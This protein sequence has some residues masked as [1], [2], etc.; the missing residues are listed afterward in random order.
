GP[1]PVVAPAV[2]PAAPVLAGAVD[3]ALEVVAVGERE[4]PALDR[5][6]R[7]EA[8][9]AGRRL[10]RASDVC[11]G[12]ARLPGLPGVDRDDEVAVP[13]R[14]GRAA[15]HPDARL[16]AAPV[17]ARLDAPAH[18]NRALEPFDPPRHLDP[19][20]ERAVAEGQRV[21]NARRAAARPVGRL[22]D[23]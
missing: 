10:E 3:P 14:H 7:E 1:R 13:L 15:A 4:R 2:E 18:P 5:G 8:T 6:E 11:V 20:P 17:E 19:P 21:R 23:V 12:D 9:R 16:A 22:E